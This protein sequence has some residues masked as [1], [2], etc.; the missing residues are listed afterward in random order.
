[1]FKM[2]VLVYLFYVFTKDKL[3]EDSPAHHVRAL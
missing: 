2:N 1:M 3:Q